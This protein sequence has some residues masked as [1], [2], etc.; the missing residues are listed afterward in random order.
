VLA[1]PIEIILKVEL[2]EQSLPSEAKRQRN[3]RYYQNK[4]RAK[5]QAERMAVIAL[6]GGKCADCG[7]D[8]IR[9]LEID[10]IFN[11]GSEHKKLRRSPASR[12]RDVLSG[13][14]DASRLQILC[15]NC[16][17]VKTWSETWL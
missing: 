1:T 14:Y 15:G 4:G 6:L 8:D 13:T 3:Q 5:F 9:M 11:D 10:H 7:E 12:N 16:H 17:N 2:Q